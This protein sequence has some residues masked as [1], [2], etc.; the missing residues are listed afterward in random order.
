MGQAKV[1]CAFCGAKNSDPSVDR[2]RIC[3]G[4]LPDAEQRRKQNATSGESFKTIVDTEV[5]VWRD[6]EEGRLDNSARS[7]RPPELPPVFAQTAVPGQPLAAP[8]PDAAPPPPPGA[9]AA[10]TVDDDEPHEEGGRLR[11]FLR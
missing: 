1:R 10:G 8:P 6:Y 9:P 5:G 11:R 3:G 4:L 7:R 2:C